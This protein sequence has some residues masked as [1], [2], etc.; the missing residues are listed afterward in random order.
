M[1]AVRVQPVD[2][3]AVARL[4]RFEERETRLRLASAAIG[5]TAGLIVALAPV[6]VTLAAAGR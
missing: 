4:A 5:L 6:L 2:A 3:D 1:A